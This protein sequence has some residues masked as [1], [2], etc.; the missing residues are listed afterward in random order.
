MALLS[1]FLED[2]AWCILPGSVHRY[3][4]P[5][6]NIAVI[7]FRN[8]DHSRHG[9][10]VFERVDDDL[11]VTMIEVER[12]RGRPRCARCPREDPQR[13]GHHEFCARCGV[14]YCSQKCRKADARKHR[15]T[16]P[17]A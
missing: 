14:C 5:P 7:A 3:I 15:R 10:L 11:N 8:R 17:P 9:L 13:S 16:C 6:Y 2:I 4:W 1:C 12:G